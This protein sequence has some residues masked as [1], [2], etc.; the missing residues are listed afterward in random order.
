MEYPSQGRSRAK[1]R[2]TRY[3]GKDARTA[4]GMVD[5]CEE[6][7]IP[8]DCWWEYYTDVHSGAGARLTLMERS[9]F[10]ERFPGLR[11]RMIRECVLKL[12]LSQ[13]SCAGR[14][15]CEGTAV[16]MQR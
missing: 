2:V 1:R 3:D 10:T 13:R 8:T 7:S 12:R 5:R 4:G 16:C 15:M 11:G 14:W 6:K 9:M